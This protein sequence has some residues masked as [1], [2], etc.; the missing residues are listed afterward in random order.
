MDP[1]VGSPRAARSFA[2]SFPRKLTC[3]EQT[4]IGDIRGNKRGDSYF[5]DYLAFSCRLKL[6]RHKCCDRFDIPI[7][8]DKLAPNSFTD[9]RLL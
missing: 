7:L 8:R 3:N 6:G 2:Q 9:R 1:V 5:L 4:G